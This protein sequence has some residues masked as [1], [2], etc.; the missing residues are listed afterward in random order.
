MGI[1]TFA[2]FPSPSIPDQLEW[3]MTLVLEIGYS[4]V[5]LEIDYSLRL[6]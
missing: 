5:V 6:I 2:F 4:G 1:C 3:V